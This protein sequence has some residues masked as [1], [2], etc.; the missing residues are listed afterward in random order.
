MQKKYHTVQTVPKSNR[1]MFRVAD[2]L[3]KPGDVL[4]GIVF[5]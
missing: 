5:L 4:V 1:K 3:L 2:D